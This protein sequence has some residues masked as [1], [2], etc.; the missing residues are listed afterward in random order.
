MQYFDRPE[1]AGTALIRR[2]ETRA[3]RGP[4]ADVPAPYST[5]EGSD[6]S[7]GS[8]GL[9]EYW[10]IARRYK[11]TL[12]FSAL[13][14]AV[15]AILIGF[16]STPIYRARTSVEVLN[17]N[18]DFM[19]MK[20]TNPVTTAD[21]SFDTSEEENQAQ[22]LQSDALV[23]RVMR[24]LD[25]DYALIPHRRRPAPMWWQ[26][27]FNIE[28]PIPLTPREKLLNKLVKSLRV[29]V[30]PRTR[31]LEVTLKSSDAQLAVDFANNLTNEFIEQT[32][33]SRW[34]TTQR[35]GQW[36]TREI[37]GERVKL[38]RSEDELQAYAKDSGLIFTDDNTNVA[39]EKLQQVQEQ[40]GRATADRITKQ[41]RY[42]LAKNS[43]PDSLPD[44][45]NDAALRDAAATIASVRA[46]V[47]LL[48]AT[49][50]P[51]Y[52]KLQQA[53]AQVS[54]L[55]AA[56]DH[57]RDAIVHRITNDYQEARR[58]EAL[59]AS[60]YDAQTR[61]VTGFDEKAVKYNILKREAD[62]NRQL[63]DTMLLQLKESSMAS[64]LN[65]TN[66]HVVDPASLPSRPVWPNYLILGPLG[67][68]SGLLFGVCVAFVREH[69]DR[70]LQQ[71]GEVQIWTNLP[72][73]GTIPSAS[74][75][76]QKKLGKRGRNSQLSES[77]NP[78]G[79][80]DA[81]AQ[82]NGQI[83]IGLMTWEH[84]PSLMA[85]AFRATLTSILFVGE[86]GSRPKV[87][88][89]TSATPGDGKTTV[90]SNLG[91]AMAEIRRNVLIIDADLRRPRIHDLFG[92]T[93][94]HG[95]SD[96][97]KEQTLSDDFINPLIQ[98]TQVPGLDVLTSGPATHAAANLFYSPNLPELLASL[99]K[100]Y[101]M[102]LI[103]TP[104]MLQMTDARV[105]GRLAD[106]VILI[107]RAHQTTR[108]AMIAASQR[109]SEDRIRVLGT[110]LNDWD[111]KQSPN[112]YYGYYSK[113]YYHYKTRTR[114][115][116][117]SALKN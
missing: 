115:S 77:G 85:E 41:S 12:I 50:G 42:E 69:A 24:K 92:L 39:T 18:E 48:S 112:G 9:F 13:G 86:N 104:P 53:K 73:L 111:P 105:I 113:S 59:L 98:K 55:Q 40:L 109:F 4:Y 3:A 103:D 71:P 19:N 90:T 97:L 23:E 101:D 67:L 49:Y 6:D 79:A 28:P 116:E 5:Y 56:F 57:D 96:L 63:Y 33:E 14:G 95:L 35:T 88:V 89:L 47:A 10:R 87:L 8:G 20:Q 51:D 75:D 54:A 99:R 107:A 43:P 62:S 25:P 32:L 2:P 29:Q 65:A 66:V 91:I 94:E 45:L 17:L 61:E 84:K 30:V 76:G 78:T 82:A 60:A 74:V 1:S 58:K 7:S 93:N 70:S 44:V 83:P 80:L 68:M 64:A 114:D 110:V 15:L 38:E 16:Y 26:E 21:Y 117:S 22:L 36:L 46:Q 72:E 34:Q 52:S 31:L 106:A 27:L 102:V 11:K 81:P 108:G 37:E 100:R